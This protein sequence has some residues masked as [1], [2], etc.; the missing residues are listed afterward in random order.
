[1][2]NSRITENITILEQQNNKQNY[3]FSRHNILGTYNPNLMELFFKFLMFLEYR[4]DHVNTWF[5]L[6]KNN[7]NTI[8]LESQKI[9]DKLKSSIT[10]AHLHE[11]DNRL[12]VIINKSDYEHKLT[13]PKKL[14][15]HYKGHLLLPNN[16]N[17]YINLSD[18]NWTQQQKDFLNLESNCHLFQGYTSINKN[19]EIEILN[20]NILQLRNKKVTW[21]PWSP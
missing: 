9:R 11:L 14:N 20:Q 7:I 4:G 21:I 5:T 1:M 16:I 12:S 18:C 15:N 10:P 3:R 13:R 17:K 19:T 6:C 2:P 8:N